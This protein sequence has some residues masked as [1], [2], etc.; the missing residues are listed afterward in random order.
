MVD[1]KRQKQE[2]G[3][4]SVN[5]FKPGAQ[6]NHCLGS[7]TYMRGKNKKLAECIYINF[8]DFTKLV[9]LKIFPNG[10]G[11]TSSLACD[12]V[13]TMTLGRIDLRKFEMDLGHYRD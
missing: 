6:V 11:I 1:D 3:G 13:K 9:D 5:F 2:S 4:G 10:Q 12:F 7:N 8:D